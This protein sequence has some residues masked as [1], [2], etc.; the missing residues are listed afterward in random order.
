MPEGCQT[1]GCPCAICHCWRKPD[2]TFFHVFHGECFCDACFTII[3]SD[4]TDRGEALA[5]RMP[6]LI[7]SEYVTRPLWVPNT[8]DIARMTDQ[9]IKEL[10][11][12]LQLFGLYAYERLADGTI[13]RIPLGELGF[14]RKTQTYSRRT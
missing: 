8:E 6:V 10:K 2:E 3:D 1:C 4:E 12:D 7:V 14:D 13:E 11:R 5:K 9:L